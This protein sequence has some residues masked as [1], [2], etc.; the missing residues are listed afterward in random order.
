M[1]MDEFSLLNKFNPRFYLFQYDFMPNEVVCEKGEAKWP[2]EG[3]I[4]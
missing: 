2:Q 4:V 3:N 1:Q